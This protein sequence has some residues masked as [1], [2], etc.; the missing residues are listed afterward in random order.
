MKTLTVVLSAAAAACLA[1]ACA[2]VEG[3]E[4]RPATPVKAEEVTLAAPESTIRYSAAI[5]ALVQVPLAFKSAG[6]VDDV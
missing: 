6:Y 5:E 1:G 4:A 3:T 2:T